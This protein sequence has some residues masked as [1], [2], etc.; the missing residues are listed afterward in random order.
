MIYYAKSPNGIVH[1]YDWPCDA[2]PFP[3]ML[4]GAWMGPSG[5]W[6]TASRAAWRTESRCHHCERILAKRKEK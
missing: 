3:W 4:C 1:A 6:V 2:E 5:K